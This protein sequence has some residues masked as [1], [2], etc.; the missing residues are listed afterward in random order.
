MISLTG[1]FFP[2]S[3]PPGRDKQTA[4]RRV[5]VDTC[6]IVMC[7]RSHLAHVSSDVSPSST[8]RCV[9]NVE[10][11]AS[12]ERPF[13]GSLVFP[14]LTDVRGNSKV[15]IGSHEAPSVPWAEA[16]LLTCFVALAFGQ[17]DEVYC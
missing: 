12:G 16:A 17:I 7:S 11:R 5:S 2:P 15:D 8:Y 6:Q 10:R 4:E 14:S 3:F 1:Y 9:R 13:A